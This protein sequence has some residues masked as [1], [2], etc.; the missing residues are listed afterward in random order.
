MLVQ[1]STYLGLLAVSPEQIIE[2]TLSIYVGGN[3]ATYLAL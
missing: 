2:A 1:V 3:I